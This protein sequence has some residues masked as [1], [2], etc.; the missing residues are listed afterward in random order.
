MFLIIINV[1]NIYFKFSGTFDQ[2]NTFFKKKKILNFWM[3][4]ST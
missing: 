1:E 2:C 4:F 3:L